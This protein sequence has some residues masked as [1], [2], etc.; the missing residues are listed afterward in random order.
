ME[1][2][3]NMEGFSLNGNCV[4]IISTKE[5]HHFLHKSFFPMAAA[6][7][8]ALSSFHSDYSDKSLFISASNE[9][10]KKNIVTQDY[11]VSTHDSFCSLGFCKFHLILIG[12]SLSQNVQRLDK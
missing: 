6:R 5:I 8:Q 3:L 4:G 11:C 10:Y 1:V 7:C 12:T 9:F 2:G